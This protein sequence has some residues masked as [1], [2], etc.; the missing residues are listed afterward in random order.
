MQEWENGV[1][2]PMNISAYNMV[3]SKQMYTIIFVISVER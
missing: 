1:V 3:L 2:T